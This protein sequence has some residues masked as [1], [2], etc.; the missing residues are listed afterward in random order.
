MSKPT[1]L[2]VDDMVPNINVFK[3]TFKRDFNII[4]AEEADRA[5]ELVKSDHIDLIIADQRMPGKTGV[6]LMREISKINPNLPKMI[7]SEYSQDK[8]IRDAMKELSILNNIHKP[9]DR[10]ELRAAIMAAISK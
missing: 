3:I 1:I 9:W 7:I 5:I 6:E 4:T 2:Y 8:V 10:D